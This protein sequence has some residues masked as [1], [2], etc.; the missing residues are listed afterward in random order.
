MTA[1]MKLKMLAP[2]KKSDGKPVAV[3]CVVAQLCLTLCDPM[4][5]SPQA[6]LSMGIVQA[7]I[8]EGLSC[9]SPGY[10]PNPRIEPRFP[11]L[12][13]HSLSSE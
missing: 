5:C 13:L 4:D 11:T 6:P 10:L 7:R 9:P 8:L 3:M 1:A 12:Q 2:W